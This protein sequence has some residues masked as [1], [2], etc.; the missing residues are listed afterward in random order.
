MVTEARTGAY[1]DI[2]DSDL[3]PFSTP[4]A[5]PSAKPSEQAHAEEVPLTP[6]ERNAMRAFLQRS[7]V[8][9]STLHRVAVAFVS[10]AGL[11]ILFP[12]F[13]KDEVVTLIRQFLQHIDAPMAIYEPN[14]LLVRLLIYG[15]L[16]FPFAISLSIPIYSMYLLIKDVVHFYFSIY[17]PGF[18]NDLI[19]PSL[20]LSG[21]GF[22]PDESPR[23][24][25]QIFEYQYNPASINFAIPFSNE[26][27]EAYFDEMIRNTDGEILPSSRRYDELLR[28]GAIPKGMDRATVERLNAAFGLARTV[29]RRLVEEVATTELSLVRHILYLRRLVLRYVKTLLMF[30]WTAIVTFIMLPIVE[31]Q[32]FPTFVVL[33]LG[34]AIWSIGVYPIM[35][36]PLKWI[37]RH[38]RG[39][40]DTNQIDQQMTLLETQMRPYVIASILLSLFSL[41]LSLPIYL[42]GS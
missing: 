24:K 26:K 22:S 20:A 31:D 39:L 36:I 2:P 7:E 27:R 11:L 12:I 23:I 18:P 38:K 16:L 32:R 1:S 14:A 10:G 34:Y 25:E 37:Y 5:Q 4:D 15:G 33:A 40:P 8:R 3:P 42:S 28:Q 9:L 30:I 41:A 35:R 13:L 17:T 21:I 29:D 6:D 19:T